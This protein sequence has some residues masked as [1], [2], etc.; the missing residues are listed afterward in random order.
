MAGEILE[1][2]FR[3]NGGTYIKLGQLLASLE[4]LVPEEIVDQMSNMYEAAP[5]SSYD[6]VRQLIKNE[7][8]RELEDV[9]EDFDPVP[10]KSGS[11]AQIHFAKLKGTGEKVAVKIQ[12]SKLREE[13]SMD[14]KVTELF[15]NIGQR[16]FSD[17]NYQW[18]IKDM[19]RNLPQELDFMIEARNCVKMG[20]LVQN[21]RRIK[22]PKIYEHITTSKILTMSF[23][24]G[25]AITQKQR[26]KEQG[27]DINAVAKELAYCFSRSI[28]EFGFVHA[29]P[30]PGNIFVRKH[31]SK[32]FELVLLDHGLYRPISREIRLAYSKLWN[33]I[34][35]QREDLIQ[36][37]CQSLGVRR[38]DFK[39]MTS[40]VT[41]QEWERARKGN[42]KLQESDEQVEQEHSE[43]SAR[44]PAREGIPT[45]GVQA[46]F[47]AAE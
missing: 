10:V 34:F 2:T 3:K 18:L 20:K 25:F 28:F 44:G 32:G 41:K 7:L 1:K 24:E 38:E 23:E 26:M 15:I 43:T 11:I 5:K 27:I 16:L 45:K 8:G 46:V 39:L 40:M 22:V 33:G 35:L 19:K 4:I 9:F 29:D 14:M 47:G 21:E 30:H 6:Y 37:S 36:E 31:A 13:L 17:F 12:H 42:R